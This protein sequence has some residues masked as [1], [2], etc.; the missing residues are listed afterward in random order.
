[1]QQRQR[2]RGAAAPRAGQSAAAQGAGAPRHAA[3]V[4]RPRLGCRLRRR[5]HGQPRKP[6]RL[7]NP[8]ARPHLLLPRGPPHKVHRRVVRARAAA[9]RA[10]GGSDRQG[11]TQL[12]HGGRHLPRLDGARDRLRVLP[13]G[14]QQSAV[15]RRRRRA[16]GAAA[17]R[18]AAGRLVSGSPLSSCCLP[19]VCWSSP[20]HRCLCICPRTLRVPARGPSRCARPTRFPRPATHQSG[21]RPAS[22]AHPG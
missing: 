14:A 10:D 21:T 17:R 9:P 11:R 13:L 22:L 19:D 20:L 16:A 2:W 3:A 5:R 4:V 6:S 18:R 12:L 8:H 1:M 15:T 7:S